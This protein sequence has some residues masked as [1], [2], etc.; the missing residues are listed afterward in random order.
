MQ[1]I[2]PMSGFGE[3]FRRQGYTVPKP[4]IVVEG[5]PI[6]EHVVEMFSPEDEFIFICNGEHLANPDYN[7]EGVLRRIAPRCK[8]LAI[9]PHRLGP[10]YAMSR[11][12]DSI[13]DNEPCIVNYCDFTCYWDYDDFKSFVRDTDSDA[14]LPCYK[15]FHPHMLGITNYAFLRHDGLWAFDIKEKEPFTSDRMSE[16]ASSGTF[17]FR[18]GALLKKYCRTCMDQELKVN[19]E[20]YVSLVHKPMFADGLKVSI[21]ELQHFM[22]WGTPEDLEEYVQWSQAFRNILKCPQ[23]AIAHRGTL[24]M[25]MAGLGSRFAKEGYETTKPLIPVSGRSMVIQAALDLPQMDRQVFVLRRDMLG[26]EGIVEELKSHFPLS[27]QVMLDGITDG[28]AR[29][30]LLG[31]AGVEL[32]EPLMI[33]ACDNGVLF[34]EARFEELMADE[35]TDVIVWAMRRYPGAI[36]NPHGYGWLEVCGE[37]VERV[38]VKIPLANPATEPVVIGAFTFKRARDFV[39]AAER[40]AASGVRVNGELYVDSCLNE[41]IALGMKVR[42]L[43]VDSYL[44]WGTPNDLRT[45]EYWQSCFLKWRG[46]PYSLAHDRRVPAAAREKLQKRF[47]HRTAARPRAL[48]GLAGNL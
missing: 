2:V 27:K 31:M 37:L 18:S 28:Q 16:F 5:K 12:F 21:Y 19:G 9:E 41:A 36:K 4:L 23:P 24:L 13:Q 38:S 47:A 35:A 14:C 44:C 34:D 22:Q 46:H 26:V 29:T 1:I 6:I 30:C 11:V 40:L 25:P 48:V 15:G 20:Y 33:G 32:D 10:V 45:F 7:L 17:Y 3:R 8:I 43:E 42:V 39:R